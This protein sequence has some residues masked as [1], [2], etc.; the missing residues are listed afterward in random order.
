MTKTI[1]HITGFIFLAAV[2]SSCGGEA[3]VSLKKNGLERLMDHLQ[4]KNLVETP[5]SGLMDRFETIEESLSGEPSLVRTLSNSR[6]KTWAAATGHTVLGYKET[7]KPPDMEVWMGK[8]PLAFY[9][10]GEQGA[11]KWQWI[12]TRK[13]F[14]LR[15]DNRF[16][17]ARKCLVLGRN[18]AYDF[19]AFLPGGPVVLEILIE[20]NRPPVQLETRINGEVHSLEQVPA[21]ASTLRL[22]IDKEPGIYSLSLSPRLEKNPFSVE[23][24]ISI[25]RIKMVTEKDLILF[26]VPSEKQQEFS[27]AEIHA[28]YLSSLD[29]QTRFASLYRIQKEL[30]LHSY[31][32]PE[33]P[34]GLK[35]K[36]EVEN[37]SL[38][39]L[40]APPS[41]R[42]SF[43]IAIPEQ[44]YLEFGTGMFR[45]AGDYEE[46]TVRFQL[47]AVSENIPEILYERKL[48]ASDKMSLEQLEIQNIDL[49]PYAGR[50]IQ[51]I[52]Q[53]EFAGVSNRDSAVYAFWMNPLVYSP[54]PKGL[55]VILVSLD[56]LRAD[57]LGGYG[58]HRNTSPCL[59][60]IAQDGILFEHVYAQSPW[61]LPSHMSLLFS[62][63]T[64]RHQVYLRNQS[65]DKS[66][67]SLASYLK[68]R[69]YV[70]TAFTGGGYMSSIYGFPKGFDRYDEPAEKQPDYRS[71]EAEYLFQT[72]ADWLTRNR[73]KKFFLFLHT[74]QIHGPYECPSP[75]NKAFLP[76]KYK[77]DRINLKDTLET[78]GSAHSFSEDEIENIIALYDAEI[79]Y[80]DEMLIKPLVNHLKDLGL[81]DRTILIFTSDH[82][83]EFYEH[84]GWLHGST[85]YN[86]QLKVPLIIKLPESK[87]A[88][89]RIPAKVRLIDIMP[90]I[91]EQVNIK[92]ENI[93]GS[94]LMSLVNGSESRDRIFLSDLANQAHPQLIPLQ[95]ATNRDNLKF[96]FTRAESGIKAMETYDL[97]NDPA[98]RNN[99]FPRAQKL[100]EEVL[101][102]LT[103]Y[104]ERQRIQSQTGEEVRLNKELE[105]K[106]KALGYLH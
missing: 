73:Y 9:Q 17:K 66:I 5:F 83:E 29:K 30:V 55:N 89:I 34:Y 3:A 67:P 21:S 20:R 22:K 61:T 53:T 26:F 65:I 101:V 58:Y 70:T 32:N 74:F 69:G 86:E 12:Q 79:Q 82:G 28:R 90:T 46:K 39:V 45:T 78:R 96:I 50:T 94:S 11:V 1:A 64:A 100:R 43:D 35:K 71:R 98:E 27:R 36:L 59:D 76:D 103:E 63:N 41:S 80:T 93:D 16:N 60:Q 33:N 102:F 7:Q 87:N 14:D 84:S 49:S 40:L 19:D 31:T 52:F 54:D 6:Q 88:G 51:L 10:D 75:W 13:T 72:A 91:L 25:H 2:I 8:Q 57:H 105:E 37:S 106:L 97:E 44:A 68:G 48:T 92:P 85:L 18:A 56:T 23:A 24:R 4:K 62:L 95:M 47:T 99:L 104:Y 42:Y 15:F 81:Y 38:D 77:W